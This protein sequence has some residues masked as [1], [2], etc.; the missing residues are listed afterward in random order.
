M[1]SFQDGARPHEAAHVNG[2]HDF[3]R[4]GWRADRAE[5]DGGVALVWRDGGG[6]EKAGEARFDAGK[7]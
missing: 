7:S 2:L 6:I 1:T 4:I 3:G 5:V